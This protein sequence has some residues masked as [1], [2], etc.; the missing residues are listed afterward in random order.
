LDWSLTQRAIAEELMDADDLD[1]ATFHQVLADLTKVNGLT[2]AYRPTLAFL[3]RVRDRFHQHRLDRV[4]RRFPSA[5]PRFARVP[6][7]L[8]DVGSGA[9]D[10]IR[11]VMRHAGR[12]GY[13]IHHGVGIDLNPRSQALAMSMTPPPW[14]ATFVTGDYR[15]VGGQEWDVIISSLV[16]HHMTHEQLVDFLRFMEA[17]AK[18]GWLINDLHRHRFAYLGFPLLARLMRWH[19]IVRH[20]G[21]L[22]IARSYRPHEWASI[23]AEAGVG[24]R[25]PRLS[26][27]PLPAVRRTP[28]L[29][30]GGGPAGAAAALLLARARSPHLLVERSAETGDA[31]CGGFLSW[32]TLETLERIGIRRS[33]LNRDDIR[34]LR[35]FAGKTTAEAWLPRPAL[36]VSRWRLDT[37]LLDHAITAGAAVERGVAVRSAEGRAVRLADEG[38]IGADALFLATGKHDLRGLARPVELAGDPT[39]G[40]RV[41]LGPSEALDRMVGGTIELHLFDRGYA[42]LARQEDGTVNCCMAVHRS[43]LSDA[44]SPDALLDAL[45]RESPR[46]GERLAWRASGAPI[47]AVANIPYGWRAA[48]TAPGLF[49]L[50]DQGACVPSLAGEGMG[51]AIESGLRA[52]SA[53]LRGG[54]EAAVAYQHRLAADLHRP[55]AVA[56]A[57]RRAAERPAW[58]SALT[59]AV[60]LAPQI[61]GIAAHL[62]R[63]RHMPLDA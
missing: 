25:R 15:D 53:W 14:P 34:R 2:L 28:A 36:A 13:W 35:L 31:L 23:L 24:V 18:L 3:R 47:D 11:K 30:V 5:R 33:A 12:H 56:G 26:R 9:G 4:L 60:R 58:A 50:G 16:A 54:P 8:L 21:R 48:D 46:L 63:I 7:R 29:I 61:A 20:D 41:R 57:I 40:L 42:G 32:R 45:A 1:A 37:L 27:L 51:I 49:R 43:R 6:L 39:L 19:P 62:T 10:Q 22:S 44:G 17:E 55:F 52:A 38:Q 59:R